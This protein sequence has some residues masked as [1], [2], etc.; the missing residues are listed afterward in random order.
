[1]N[2]KEFFKDRLN[3]IQTEVNRVGLEISV[4]RSSTST[5]SDWMLS[6]RQKKLNQLL[7]LVT[8]TKRLYQGFDIREE[9]GSL[10]AYDDQ[11]II[12]ELFF[13]SPNETEKQLENANYRRIPIKYN[14]EFVAIRYM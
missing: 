4:M 9:Y 2:T 10:W 7:S 8:E 14:G 5:T 6:E 11:G 3:K 12:C 13:I 1:M